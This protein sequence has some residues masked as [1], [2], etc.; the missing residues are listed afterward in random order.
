MLLP[1]ATVFLLLLCNDREVLGPWVNR[2]WLNVLAGLIVSVLVALSLILMATTV[3]PHVNVMFVVALLGAVL[4]VGGVLGRRPRPAA[5]SRRE[6]PDEPARPGPE[7]ENW[8]MPPPHAARAPVLSRGRRITMVAMWGYLAVAVVAPAVKA[9]EL[10]VGQTLTLR[11]FAG[12][13]ARR[14]GLSDASLA[15]RQARAPDNRHAA[16]GPAAASPS[17]STG[18]TRAAAARASTP[19]T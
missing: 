8:R 17:S 10:G 5:R 12:I 9:V 16:D 3:F 13:A 4:V 15:A 18:A 19:A 11:S 14:R 2:L 1:S 6:I 7:R